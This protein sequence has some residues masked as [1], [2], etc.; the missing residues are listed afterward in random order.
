MVIF[1]LSHNEYEHFYRS[2]DPL[3]LRRLTI[4]SFTPDSP[5]TVDQVAV[6]LISR[7]LIITAKAATTVSDAYELPHFL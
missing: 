3:G 7:V 1:Y 5:L 6:V 4:K 2:Y